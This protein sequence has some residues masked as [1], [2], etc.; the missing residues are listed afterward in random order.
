MVFSDGVFYDPS[1]RL[2]KMWYMGGYQQHTAMAVSNDG[3]AWRRPR[4]PIVPGT[5]IVL[6]HHRDSS[7]VWL[8]H[9]DTDPGSRF[10]M[11]CYEFGVKGM[12]RYLSPDGIHWRPDGLAGPCGDRSTMFR[13][14]FRGVWAFS[15]RHDAPGTLTRTRLYYECRAFAN[16]RWHEGE[17]VPW[18]GADTLDRPRADYRTAPQLYA[19]DAVGYESVM[20]GLFTMYRG[21]W[22]DREKPNDVCVAF[23]R[24]GFHWSR[25]WR[26]P[27][28]TVSEEPGAWNWSNVQSAGGGC[29]VAGDQLYFYASGRRGIRGTNMPGECSTGLAILRRDGFASLTDRWPAGMPRPR[30]DG[31]AAVTTRP[32]RFSGQHLFINARTRG[33]IR[34]EILDRSGQ[35]VEPFSLAAAVPVTGDSTKQVVR[36]NHSASLAAVIN[37]DVRFRFVL[38]DAELFSFWVSRS[39]AGASQGYVAA[40]G[41]GF[42][43]GRDNG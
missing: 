41:P 12:R 28:L 10:K 35:I 15:L 13:N 34:V 17:P 8:D 1:D 14:P 40:G 21:E 4:L 37:R 24:D 23:S 20:L 36:W 11:S 6:K 5:N 16:A 2:F 43:G 22:S 27:F 33:S 39:E 32:V 7:T 29:I 26:E 42:A 30:R 18:V 19:L 3:I 38:S 31:E 25:E 9:E